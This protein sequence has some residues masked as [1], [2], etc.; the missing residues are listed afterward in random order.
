M[1]LIHNATFDSGTRVL[2]LLDKAGNVI[3]SCEVPS[4]ELV[5]DITKPLTFKA[6]Q[7]GST[8]T[9]TKNG[10]PSGTFQTSRDGGNT[11]TDYTLNTDIT[12]NNGDEVSFRAKTNRTSAQNTDNY[13]HF[14]MTGK[15]EA[16]HNVMS[17]YRTN[18]FATFN[19]V[20]SYAFN[21][22]FSNCT[23]LTK[24]PALPATRLAEYCYEC[25]F[26]RASSLT[27]APEL[28]A[29]T[30]VDSCYSNMFNGA[31][32]LTKA[33][34]LPATTLAN[35]C[36]QSMFYGCQSLKE[37]RVS[38]TRTATDALTDWLLDVPATGDFYCDPNA[39]IFPT[40]TSGIPSGW[41]RHNITDYPN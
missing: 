5:D 22:M 7:D 28:P 15:I 34:E 14:E 4:K 30:L 18:D 40:G 10:S 11:W 3:S 31:F 24:A 39:T 38:A 36:Y 6:I 19:A 2:S 25:M 33:P 20:V 17:L 21:W 1:A 37:V 12:L 29:T 26:Y 32:S 23:S 27:K 13:F 35:N 16:W 9:L 41:T 8:V